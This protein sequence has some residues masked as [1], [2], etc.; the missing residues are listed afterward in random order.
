MDK[1]LMIR[2]P[3]VADH[4]GLTLLGVSTTRNAGRAET[5]GTFGSGS[6][7]SLA[8][9]LRHNISPII[10]CGTL[11][12]DFDSK[13]VVVKGQPF[14]QMCIRFS[15]KDI[16]GRSRSGSEDMGIVTGWGAADWDKVS[17]AVRE[18]ISNAIDGATLAGGSYRGVKLDIVDKPRCADGYTTVYLPMTDEIQAAY[19]RVGDMFLHFGKPEHLDKKCLPKR[20]PGSN[21]I[22]VYKKGVLTSYLRGRSV[23][24]YNLGD[25]LKLDESRNSNEWDV[26]HSVAEALKSESVDTL[27]ELLREILADPKMWEAELDSYNLCLSDYAKPEVKQTRIDTLNQ[28]W[29]KAAGPGA[30]ATR[31]QVGI[32][33]FVQRKGFTPKPISVNWLKALFSYKVPTEL[34]VLDKNELEGKSVSEPTTAMLQMLKT[35]WTMLESL[36]LTNGKA[37][38]VAK[39]FQSI[40]DG[41]GTTLGYF[42]P[43]GDTIYLHTDLGGKGLFKTVLEEISHYLTGASDMSRD[44][45]EYFLSLITEQYYA[46]ND[47]V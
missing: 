2:N 3:G 38:P 25:E 10:C 17:M 41:S 45:Q 12:L 43:G 42:L 1:Y 9:L 19:G 26:R 47:V 21:Q 14:N 8:L 11:R 33:S 6:K 34:D 32:D 20:H 5:I 39:S 22:L 18:F 24:D 13:S 29:T 30:V 7:Y 27:A 37:P 44:I 35:V 40:A 31:G 16:D 23:F 46:C 4:R 15:G 28:A 36:K